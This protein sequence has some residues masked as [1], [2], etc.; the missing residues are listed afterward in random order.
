MV[1][2]KC[3]R[4][5]R[6][7]IALEIEHDP[8]GQG[9]R[10]GRVRIRH[11]GYGHNESEGAAVEG[12]DVCNRPTVADLQITRGDRI[13]PH[14]FRESQIN[15]RRRREQ[16]RAV[17]RRRGDHG[18]RSILRYHRRTSGCERVLTGSRLG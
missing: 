4:E 1:D 16:A 2:G 8:G 9:D 3:A 10:V 7:R 18:W 12:L 13:D 17:G 15:R 5:R 14:A 6:I 11:I